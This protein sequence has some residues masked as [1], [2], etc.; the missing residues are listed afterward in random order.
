[1]KLVEEEAP[2]IRVIGFLLSPG[3]PLNKSQASNFR[4]RARKGGGNVDPGQQGWGWGSSPEMRSSRPPQPT[5]LLLLHS[6][7]SGKKKKR[8]A[9][10][11]PGCS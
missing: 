8:F 9:E 2:L 6:K 3:F 5:G 11:S 10:M 4:F 7:A 1:M